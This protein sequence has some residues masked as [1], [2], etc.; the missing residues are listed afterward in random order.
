MTGIDPLEVQLRA[1][2]TAL[3]LDLPAVAIKHLLRYRAELAH[4]NRAYN[5]TAVRDARGM[6]VRHL[7][8]AAAAL[9]SL[10]ATLSVPGAR[11]LDVGSGAGVPGIVWGIAHPGCEITLLDSNGKKAR[12]LRHAA[13]VLALD[14]LKVAEAR[15]EE[16]NDAPGYDLITSRAF[17]SLGDFLLGTRHLLAPGGQWAALKGKLAAEELAAV[18]AE[19]HIRETLR[20]QVP[21][22]DEVRHLVTVRP[23]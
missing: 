9:P 15:V 19:F 22:L 18:P 10:S 2:L 13:R 4:W 14:N 17:A 8:D 20:L 16:W 3:R 5:L 21:G 12:F 6:V 1:G 11:A 7:L 23:A